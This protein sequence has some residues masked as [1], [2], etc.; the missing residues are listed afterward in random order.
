MAAKRTEEGRQPEQQQD[1][2]SSDG[3]MRGS[4]DADSGPPRPDLMLN[5]WVSWLEKYFGAARD[6]IDTDKPWWSV[7]ADEVSG[8]ML[9]GGVKQLNDILLQDPILR[10]IDQMWNANPLREVVPVDWAEITRA[11]RTVWLYSSRTPA[12]GMAAVTELN[13][14]LWRSAIDAWTEASKGWWGLAGP[15]S[16]QESAP[17]RSDKRFAAPEWHN[18]PIYRTLRELYLVAS[19]WLL[20]Q[21]EIEGM[22]E[23]ERQR[24]N[25]HLRQ[26]VDAMSPALLLVSN[27]TALRRAMETGGAS[28]AEG[29]RNLLNDLKEHRL[30]IVDLTAFAPGRNLALTPGQVVHRNHL[31]ELIQYAPTTETVHETP[32]LIVPHWINKYYI[33]DMQPKN[34]MVRYLECVRKLC[35]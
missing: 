14:T 1:K 13:L 4:S 34:S 27:P 9:A 28:L 2:V 26:F 19:D 33:L 23:A 11:L 24:L 7:T 35:S 12:K 15:D 20:K 29:A 22:D 10:S 21:G 5:L 31:M 18:N 17:P 8:K 16:S 3:Q 25:F 30:S 32:L 6:W